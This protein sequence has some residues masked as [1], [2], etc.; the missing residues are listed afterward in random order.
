MRPRRATTCK[1]SSSF[2]RLVRPVSLPFSYPCPSLT[3]P[4]DTGG[5][6][7]SGLGTLLLSKI[8]EEVNVIAVG[9]TAVAASH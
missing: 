2:T 6:T 7:G 5:G 3:T 8:R 1:A 4:G 9:S